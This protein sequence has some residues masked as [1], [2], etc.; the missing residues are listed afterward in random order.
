MRQKK[1]RRENPNPLK[2]I[3]RFSKKPTKDDSFLYENE[4]WFVGESDCAG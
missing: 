2:P 3:C 4:K 1:M